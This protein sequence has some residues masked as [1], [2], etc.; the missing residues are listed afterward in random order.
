MTFIKGPGLHRRDLLAGV[1]AS[2]AV[3][4]SST[5]G[6]AQATPK[7]GGRFRLGLTGNTTD[8]LDPATFGGSGV[9]NLGL[10]GATYNNLTE[11]APDGSL[12]GELAESFETSKDAKTWMFKL[13]RG[14]T[15]HSGKLLDADD[16]VASINHHRGGDSKS[17]AK[18]IVD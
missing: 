14:V 2:A 5:D 9:I 12:V 4:A 7:K 10:W 15:F 17:A 13:R 18:G 16:V 6:A 8:S 3:I 11:I 1:T